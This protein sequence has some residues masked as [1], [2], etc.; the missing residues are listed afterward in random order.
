MTLVDQ[1]FIKAFSKSNVI[2]AAVGEPERKIR[3]DRAHSRPAP[4]VSPATASETD[5]SPGVPNPHFGSAAPLSDVTSPPHPKNLPASTSTSTDPSRTI[6]PPVAASPTTDFRAAW[7]VDHYRWPEVC[8][9][10][11]MSHSTDLAPS[12]DQI[13]GRCR[14][15][16]RIL[17]VSGEACGVGTT[18]VTLFI[19]RTLSSIGYSVALL[20]TDASKPDLADRL[21]LE[22]DASWLDVWRQQ[23]SLQEAAVTSIQD[24]VTLF[25]LQHSVPSGDLGEFRRAAVEVMNGLANH[26][27]VVLV[28][29]GSF[30]LDSLGLFVAQRVSGISLLC[31]RDVGSDRSA[32]VPLADRSLPSSIPVIG[33]AENF[34]A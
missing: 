15:G 8:R 10:L 24:K 29:G 12:V 19:A 30:S 5:H 22:T 1:A 16:D 3:V 25:P 23:L 21:E 20:D 31:V 2:P 28:D 4:A 34:A 9:D 18:T 32:G 11:L 7:E 26:F 27:D 6:Q 14:M 13:I 17:V 33:V